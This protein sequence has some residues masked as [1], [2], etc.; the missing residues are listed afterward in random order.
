MTAFFTQTKVMYV[1]PDVKV[2]Q[3]GKILHVLV[4]RGTVTN[5]DS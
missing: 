5:S 4:S 3:E 2:T 1:P